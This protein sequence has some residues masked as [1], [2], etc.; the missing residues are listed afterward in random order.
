MA[1]YEKDAK[2]FASLFKKAL[3]D[4][5]GDKKKTTKE[6]ERD[7][8]DLTFFINGLK[9]KEQ[10]DACLDEYLKIYTKYPTEDRRS[11]FV[12]AI[13]LQKR[14]EMSKDG[15]KYIEDISDIL[16]DNQKPYRSPIKQRYEDLEQKEKAEIDSELKYK[17][18]LKK[19]RTSILDL[20]KKSYS[21]ANNKDPARQELL[22]YDPAPDK[23]LEKRYKSLRDKCSVT[24]SK[25]NAEDIKENLKE[26]TS[27]LSEQKD[28]SK[29]F[30]ILKWTRD[31]VIEKRETV[32]MRD[33]TTKTF[34][35]P[36]A[37]DL[38]RELYFQCVFRLFLYAVK[39]GY[40]MNYKGFTSEEKGFFFDP[41]S[42]AYFSQ[43]YVNRYI[44]G[45]TK[46]SEFLD[47]SVLFLR[48]LIFARIN[49]AELQNNEDT[50]RIKKILE[51]TPKAELRKK[52]FYMG[53]GPEVF[54]GNMRLGDKVGKVKIAHF[55]N[56]DAANTSVKQIYVEFVGIEN[57]LFK[58]SIGRLSDYNV[59]NFYT[60]LW[61]NTR[62]LLKLIPLIFQLLGYT[63]SLVT[64]GLSA[65]AVDIATDVIVGE[66]SEAANLGPGASMVLSTVASGA[67]TIAKGT[68]AL[69]N[70]TLN[71]A[72][73]RDLANIAGDEARAFRQVED[74]MNDEAKAVNKT[75][76]ATTGTDVNVRMSVS[77][78]AIRNTGTGRYSQGTDGP[79]TG[80]INQGTGGPG[81]GGDGGGRI[82]WNQPG[83]KP[84]AVMD[85]ED[86]LELAQRLRNDS[87]WITELGNLNTQVRNLTDPAMRQAA[88]RD[89]MDRYAV[90]T[91]IEIE[92]I[93]KK[94]AGRYGIGP[95]NWGTY[96]PDKN[97]IY[98]HEDVLTLKRNPVTKKTINPV[99]EI[100]HE[101]AVAELYRVYKLPKNYIPTLIGVPEDLRKGVGVKY[102]ND[103]ID[104]YY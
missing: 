57:L 83:R 33:G 100:G 95:D 47:V 81:G 70:G 51:K 54:R 64:G 37:S 10:I 27:F 102:L 16:A 13:L 20:L 78:D 9:K 69:V 99:D 79:G 101:V 4:K 68:G 49:D 71:K 22:D 7:Y 48:L 63:F 67:P 59:Q 24:W 32:T 55:E 41:L 35:N 72:L 39:H 56:V 43:Q 66:Y 75:Q 52:S 8:Y 25:N 97:R 103:V 31:V 34:K 45:L 58:I 44:A 1:K 65:L 28:S 30:Q 50:S 98:I 85:W 46:A 42:T 17:K 38:E 76:T 29:L 87:P 26:F 53:V 12:F 80:R 19:Q 73:S 84:S 3:T 14:I 60:T 62:H 18:T 86:A 74:L 2:K 77:D 5:E 15:D 23:D 104:L 6:Q 88:I 93:T 90:A 94:N 91:G 11:K 36:P 82:P 89:F 40:S 92:V 21:K 61:M 96:V